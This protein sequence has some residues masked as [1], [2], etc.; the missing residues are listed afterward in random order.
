MRR[1]VLSFVGV[2]LIAAVAGCYHTAGRCDCDLVDPCYQR[3][4]WAADGQMPAPYP[5]EMQG[6]GPQPL[7]TL[8]KEQ[9]K[10]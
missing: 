4:P 10:L 7:K 2:G 1:F 5:I 9:K 6:Q 8:P 3:A